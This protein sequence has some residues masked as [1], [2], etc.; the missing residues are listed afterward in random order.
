MSAELPLGDAPKPIS[1][2][3][4]PIHLSEGDTFKFSCHKGI[5]CFTACCSDTNIILGP[6]DIHRLKKRLGDAAF[7]TFVAGVRGVRSALE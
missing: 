6:Y 5:K 7:Q 3:L 1:E 2:P 4:M